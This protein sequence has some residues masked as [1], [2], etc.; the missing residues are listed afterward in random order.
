MD[1]LSPRC[2]NK[3]LQIWR[4]SSSDGLVTF[5]GKKN[6]KYFLS[7]YFVVHLCLLHAETVVCW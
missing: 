2:L 4:G 1:Y 7:V 5:T 6:Q 3:A